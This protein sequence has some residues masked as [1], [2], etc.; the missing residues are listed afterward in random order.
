MSWQ[1][2]LGDTGTA[3]WISLVFFHSLWLSLVAFLISYLREMKA[4]VVRS[5]WC[6]FLLLLLLGLP[7]ITW[8]IPQTVVPLLQGSEVRSTSVPM[9]NS[10]AVFSNGVLW[11]KA[12]L[13]QVHIKQWTR[14]INQ[15]GLL[16]LAVTLGFAARL[17][18]GLAFLR[19]YC[20]G[21]QEVDSDRISFMLQE[22]GKYFGFRKKPRVFVS[23]QLRSPISIG[24]QT[25]SVILP[26]SLYQ[27]IGDGEL[28]AILL[29]ELAHIYHYDHVLGLL[30]RAVKALYWW[31]PFVY[32]LCNS[33]SV[34]REEISDNYAISGMES[35]ERYA[36]LLLSLV[37]KTSL[38]SRMPCTASMAT[39][40]ESLETRIKNIVS[41]E[42]DMRVKANKKVISIVAV[43]T[44]LLC[45]LVSVAS[46]VDVFGFEQELT[47][48][49]VH[50]HITGTD[51]NY[52]NAL[53]GSVLILEDSSGKKYQSSPIAVT[54]KTGD[55][56]SKELILPGKYTLTMDALALKVQVDIPPTNNTSATLDMI[57]SPKGISIRIRDSENSEVR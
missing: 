13:A 16:W 40:Y 47:A 23:P 48:K 5:T 11:V 54:G 2:F 1:S 17:L 57:I 25:S 6:T 38:I 24:I 7:L 27:H 37:E 35:A 46:Q 26:S 49:T 15:V 41:K 9:V 3:N 43:A 10:N 31:N 45:G 50:V 44:V 18:Y 4:P 34:A 56:E 32:C 51:P 42:R 39:P 8:L 12:P 22:T 14:L 30:Q 19:G 20:H 28:R 55:C 36:T 33:L 21:L 53:N 52:M 29:H